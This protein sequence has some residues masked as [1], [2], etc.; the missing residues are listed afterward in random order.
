M[1]DVLRACGGMAGFVAV[2]LIVAVPAHNFGPGLIDAYGSVV[3]IMATF[4]IGVP[5]WLAMFWCFGW[6]IGF[7]RPFDA[8]RR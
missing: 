6:A 5:L 3:T 8:F 2:F 4:L 7:D 1:R